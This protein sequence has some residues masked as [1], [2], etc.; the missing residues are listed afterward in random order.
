MDDELDSAFD[1]LGLDLSKPQEPEVQPVPD[2]ISD[3]E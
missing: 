3:E 2:V 1:D